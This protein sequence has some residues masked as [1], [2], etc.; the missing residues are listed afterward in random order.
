M[1]SEVL[2]FLTSP[3]L[4]NPLSSPL[5][6]RFPLNN[7]T[8]YPTRCVSTSSGGRGGAGGRWYSNSK[9]PKD[10][11][12]FS[13]DDE[14]RANDKGE[15][16]GFGG[17]T[18]QRIWWSGDPST[19]G[20]EY[21]VEDEEAGIDG[22]GN[23][24]GSIGLSWV[25]K[26]LR[27]FGWMFPAIIMSV[28]LG[29]GTNTIIMALALPLAQSALSLVMDAIW[30]WSDEGPRS[31][32]KKKKRR[33]AR[34]ASNPGTRMGK[35]ENTRNGKVRDYQSSNGAPDRKKSGSTLNFGGW[36]ELDNHRM[37]GQQEKAL[38]RRPAEPK[39][40]TDGK[41]SK[42]IGRRETPFVLRLLIAVFPF[43][44]SWTK[45]L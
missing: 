19:W 44:G 7:S 13:W 10:Y 36:D 11:Q 42:R 35:G 39:Q 26:V 14:I 15:E 43:L 16:F 34:E 9:R 24:E 30:G 41:L 21:D 37:E 8:S 33:Y 4:F 40:L 31:N 29:T 6:Y 28:V 45:L 38:N 2:Q 25:M 12:G 17:S 22:F 23:M 32:Y 1:G 3:A 18:K 20:D 27:A 5:R